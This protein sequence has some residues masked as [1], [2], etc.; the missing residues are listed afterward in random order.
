LQEMAGLSTAP[1][2]VPLTFAALKEHWNEGKG[3]DLHIVTSNLSHARP[4]VLP[5][6]LGNFV[7]QL[8]EWQHFFPAPILSHLVKHG[9]PTRQVTR[10]GSTEPIT[11][12]LPDGYFFFPEQKNPELLP[13]IPVLVAVRLSISFPLL[14]SAVPLYTIDQ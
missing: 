6:D 14:M 7:F 11:I 1:D 13:E 9:S 2:A 4:Y 3:V 12:T 5:D 8:A 10:V